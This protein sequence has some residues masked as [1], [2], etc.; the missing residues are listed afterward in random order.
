MLREGFAGGQLKFALASCEEHT[1]IFVGVLLVDFFRNVA[2]D[3]QDT[4]LRAEEV[5]FNS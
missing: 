2:V 4:A 3:V 1:A 5:A